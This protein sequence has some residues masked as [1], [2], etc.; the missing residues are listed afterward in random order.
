MEC[1]CPYGRRELVIN[2]EGYGC[3]VEGY[4]LAVETTEI[5]CP[6]GSTMECGGPG[7]ICQNAEGEIMDTI[8]IEVSY[9]CPK[10]APDGLGSKCVGDARCEY[11]KE[12]CCGECY[13]SEVYTCSN[14]QWVMFFTDAC[15]M[16]QCEIEPLVPAKED[17]QCCEE[18][19][20]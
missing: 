18:D 20:P 8:D 5:T 9:E 19:I 1:M 12:C 10:D 6:D 13:P 3:E 4:E 16:P 15:M 2:P 11:G 17:I 14:G 7:W